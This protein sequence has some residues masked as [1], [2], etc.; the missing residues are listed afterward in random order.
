M[1]YEINIR[2][3]E[4]KNQIANTYFH[5]FNCRKIIG[6]IDFCLSIENKI[7]IQSLLWAKAKKEFRIFINHLFS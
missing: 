3:E 5:E 1:S 4:L 2:E 6:N 7:D